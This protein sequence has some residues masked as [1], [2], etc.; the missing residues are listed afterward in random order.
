MENRSAGKQALR[1]RYLSKRDRMT[2]SERL[3]GSMRIW[4]NLKG[5]RKFQEASIVL[6]YLD[7]RSEVMTTGL[8]EEILLSENGKR[9]FAPRVEGF[10]IEFYEIYSLADLRPGYQGIRE[11][12]AR[13]ETKFTGELY[14]KNKCILLLPG[15]VYDRSLGRMG[16]GKGFYDRF[17]RRFP[18]LA[19]IGLAFECQI[20]RAVPVEAHDERVD[21]IVTQEAV[22]R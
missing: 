1:D 2:K 4:K 20:A 15:S 5:E 9:V 6:V 21:M 3:A 10:D 18:L 22:I 16:Y 12:Q 14:E 17:L 19:R 13:E 8:V 7:Y 11:P